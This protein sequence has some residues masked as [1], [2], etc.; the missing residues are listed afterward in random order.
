MRKFSHFLHP[1]CVAS[2]RGGCASETR[3]EFGR[4]SFK[5]AAR[6]KPRFILKFVSERFARCE[7]VIDRVIGVTFSVCAVWW[8][9]FIGQSTTEREREIRTLSRNV[10][11]SYNHALIRDS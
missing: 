9:A 2:L 3:R 10:K 4:L 5:S 7:R 6:E 8:L 1:L 11:P